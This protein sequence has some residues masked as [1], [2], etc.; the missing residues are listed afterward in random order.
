ML[1]ESGNVPPGRSLRTA[2]GLRAADAPEAVGQQRVSRRKDETRPGCGKAGIRAGWASRNWASSISSSS[3]DPRRFPD[4][5]RWGETARPVLERDKDP[6]D[7]RSRRCVAEPQ[8]VRRGDP[9]LFG[10]GEDLAGAVRGP[11][12]S[13]SPPPLVPDGQLARRA[14]SR[15]R[16]AR[17][18]SARSRVEWRSSRSSREI[19][20]LVGDGHGADVERESCGLPGEDCRRSSARS[21][22]ET[23]E[24]VGPLTRADSDQRGRSAFAPRSGRLLFRK[25]FLELSLARARPDED[26][27]DPGAGRRSGWR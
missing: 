17:L 8:V 18:P 15:R 14:S 26:R 27:A 21:G 7:P 22:L 20:V 16:C 19:A 12:P 25:S 13:R 9:G 24:R 1:G 6:G 2:P 5:P 11:G 3:G 10:E 23:A 4:P